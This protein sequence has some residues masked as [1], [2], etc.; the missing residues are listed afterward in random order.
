MSRIIIYSPSF[1]Y[2]VGGV[3]ALHRAHDVLLRHGFDSELCTTA[4]NE[5][6]KY[7][8][9]DRITRPDDIVIYP[10]IVRGNPLG[11]SR[12]VRYILNLVTVDRKYGADDKFIYYNYRFY[13][14]KDERFFDHIKEDTKRVVSVF[15][16]RIDFYTNLGSDRSGACYTFRKSQG[17]HIQN[18][19]HPNGSR[20]LDFHLAPERIKQEFNRHQYFYSYDTETYLSAIAA[21]CGCISVVVDPSGNLTRKDVIENQPLLKYGVAFGNSDS[22]IEHAVSTMPKVRDY[23]REYEQECELNF[24][25]HIKEIISEFN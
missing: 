16:S 11:I 1:T 13:K 4:V 21:L 24:I 6:Y 22:E 10:E 14:G 2:Q 23:L 8:I 25:N 5:N 19:L 18:Y 12:V 17:K 15:D 3:V 9:W 20:F 7:K